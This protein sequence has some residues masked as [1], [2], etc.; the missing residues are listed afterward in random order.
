MVAEAIVG[1]EAPQED[2]EE[3]FGLDGARRC[4]FMLLEVLTIFST[5]ID[6]DRTKP[7][8]ASIR[9]LPPV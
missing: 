6:E 9:Q 5:A 2:V 8:W 7:V 1:E 3:T 4:L